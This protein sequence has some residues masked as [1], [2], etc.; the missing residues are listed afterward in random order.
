MNNFFNTST[1][2]TD[3]L[4]A[5]YVTRELFESLIA[6]GMVLPVPAHTSAP[7]TDEPI[8]MLT[9]K[10]CQKVVKGVSYYKIRSMILKGELKFERSGNKP[11]GKFLVYKSSLL[12][13]FNYAA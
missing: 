10:Q 12:E 4:Y 5:I 3:T 7:D 8:E 1:P 11:H 6:G 2:T 13:R 9:I